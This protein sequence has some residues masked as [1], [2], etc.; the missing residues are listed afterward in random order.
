MRKT[1]LIIFLILLSCIAS[2]DVT[3]AS[4]RLFVGPD[5]VDLGSSLMVINGN[6][7]VPLW[8]VAEHLGANIRWSA[9]GNEVTVEFPDQ[10]I[11]MRVNEE[12]ALVDDT[13]YT[14]D[15]PPQFYDGDLMVP[16]R[17]IANQRKLSIVFVPELMGLQ[18][19]GPD[20]DSGETEKILTLDLEPEERLIVHKPEVEQDLKDIIYMGGPRSRIFIDLDHYTG[21]QTNLLV[22]PDRLVIDLYGVSGDPLPLREINGPIVTRIRSSRFDDQTMRIVCDLSSSTGYRISPWPDGGIEVEFNYQLTELG[23]ERVDGVPR[24]WFSAS[25]QPP[26]EVIYLTDPV[27]LVVDLQDTTLIGSAQEFPV[28]DDVVRRVR[29]SQHM[30][31]ITRIVLELEGP[32]APLPIEERGKNQ[33]EI[34]LFEGTQAEAAAY[35]AALGQSQEP[36][37][38]SETNEDY[39]AVRDKLTETGLAGKTIVV[40]P[41]HG[42]SDP[43]AIGPYGTFEKDV[44]LATSLFLGELLEE[45]GAKVV[46]TREA[47]IYVSIFERPE[48]ARRANADIFVSI[49]TNAYLER[50]ARGTETLYRHGDKE[51]ERLA[52][53]I[54][55][56]LVKAISLLDRGIRQRDDLAVLNG[57]RVPAALVEIGFINHVDEEVLLRSSGFQKAAAQGIFNGIERYFLEVD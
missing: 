57:S 29:V 54:Q 17:F 32:M 20:L 23:Y 38:S 6:I 45:A 31:S 41:G 1:A 22:N 5:E 27:R 44:V 33:F 9:K 14:L 42:G 49:H 3:N 51:G 46:Y 12:S 4:L 7:M 10:T 35:L 47:D 25:E 13:V 30:P 43:G 21:Y 19:G 15:V 39:E 37:P 55:E 16:I 11:I 48:I 24:L 50:I 53:I 52:Q 2:T 36:E 40:D 18:I 28:S 34:P 26:I 56:E 8:V